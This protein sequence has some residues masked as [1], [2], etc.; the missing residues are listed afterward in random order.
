[1]QV[2]I[3]YIHIDLLES[4][5]LCRFVSLCTK[6]AKIPTTNSGNGYIYGELVYDRNNIVGPIERSKW[7]QRAQDAYR[8]REF[9]TSVFY[10]S[11]AMGLTFNVDFMHKASQSFPLWPDSN[12]KST[13]S[14]VK[15]NK[16]VKTKP[17]IKTEHSN[18]LIDYIAAQV[19]MHKLESAINNLDLNGNE[20]SSKPLLT[21][22]F[23]CVEHIRKHCAALPSEWTV[24]QISKL[25]T[26]FN[27]FCNF[28]QHYTEA[29]PIKFSA[30]SYARSEKMPNQ[31]LCFHLETAGS[32]LLKTV[33]NLYYVLYK[34]DHNVETAK[35][36][37]IELPKVIE[38]LKLWMGPWIV[39][40]SGKIR[41][42][43]GKK[44][45]D[46][47]YRQVDEFTTTH[48]LN[49]LQNIYLSQFARRIDIV[50]ADSIATVADFLSN[51]K[52]TITAIMKFL[53]TLKLSLKFTGMQYYPCLLVLDEML[54]TIP[55]E[56]L[57]PSQETTRFNSI[58]M[59]FDL[60]DEYKEQISDGYLKKRMTTGN[61]L[62]NPGADT[63]LDTMSKRMS[64]FSTYWFP[65][66]TQIVKEVPKDMVS[67]LTGADVYVYMGHGA[68]FQYLCHADITDIKAKSVML[69]FGCES[70]CMN[71]HGRNAEAS[72]MHMYMQAS[73]CP[74][75]LGTINIVTDLWTDLVCMMICSRWIASAKKAPWK[76]KYF[77]AGEMNTR[78][79]DL[80]ANIQCSSEP[81]LL[82]NLA[83]IRTEKLITVRIR[84][85]MICR[86]LPVLNIF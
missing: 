19:N 64:E 83:L 52:A 63:K 50:S 65:Q 26:E 16:T 69:L 78:A 33:H 12:V 81:S 41:G 11:V 24:V 7:F 59:L 66:Y 57:L 70:V 29:R 14:A 6:A 31:P 20:S 56:M 38:M 80:M 86:G 74:A 37:G 2:N 75:L 15:A 73:K 60:Y 1:M 25:N 9:L 71:F 27:S 30:I 40:L 46:N 85:A 32:P 42:V 21:D 45:E 34:S 61:V 43:D 84:S 36:I 10:E 55:W 53:S 22:T 51:D 77:G 8:Q 82:A 23:A 35:E 3:I 4:N 49:D 54:D 67:V 76:P 18:C 72:A 44:F 39:F 17:T 13:E 28:E 47:I 5:F 68:S 48:K 62:I 79:M 58:Y